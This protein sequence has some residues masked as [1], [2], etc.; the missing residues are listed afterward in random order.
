M[1]LILCFGTRPEAIKLAPIINMIKK[2]HDWIDLK[3]CLT[4]QHDELL[5]QVTSF[6]DIQ[7]DY[8]LNVMKQSH[9][10]ADVTAKTLRKFTPIL[11]KESPDLLMVQGDT[12]SAFA[13]SLAAFFCKIQVSH[14]EAGL[15]TYD[16]FAPFPEEVNRRLI[17]PVSAL[18]FSPTETAKQNLLKEGIKDNIYVVGNT[19]IDAIKI[20]K[21]SI[22]KSMS[23]KK[24]LDKKFNF[25]DDNKKLILVTG[26]RRE[27]FGDPLKNICLALKELANKNS[28]QIV[29]PVHLNPNVRNNVNK[30]LAGVENVFLIDPVDYLEMVH[31]MDKSY[32]IITDSGGIQEETTFFGKPI[33]ITREKTE[34]PEVIEN[35]NGIL[36]GTN[37]ENI[38]DN[39][40]ALFIE[41]NYSKLAKK[42]YPYGKGNTAELIMEIIEQKFKRAT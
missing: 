8:N 33:L 4:G 9:N 13:A 37:I 28:M 42:T 41:N 26:H 11:E 22:D 40:N 39:A 6:F 7:F 17:A 23:L 38:V 25:I 12:I 24:V 29:Y 2:Q 14:V 27:N 34:R 31:L 3:L 18:H 15:R 30:I 10:L 16:N 1:K 32:F 35:G 5:K 36:V 19:S 20:T 21:E